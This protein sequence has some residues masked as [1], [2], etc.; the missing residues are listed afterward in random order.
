M[1]KIGTNIAYYFSYHFRQA[2]S[3]Y[4]SI[5]VC[6]LCGVVLG[7]VL[8]FTTTFG[9]FVLNDDNQLLF[10]FVSCDVS[11]AQFVVSKIGN[12]LIAFLILFVCSLSFYSS[13]ICF[14]FF[15]YQNLL[16]SSCCCEIAGAYGTLGF[17][18]VLFVLIPVNVIMFLV[19]AYFCCVCLERMLLAKKYK[20]SLKTSF[21][22]KRH[23]WREI[24][25][26]V[27][28]GVLAILLL[29]VVYSILL[30]NVSFVVF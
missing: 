24:V 10:D 16:L 5:F 27:S 30:R 22:Y 26:A 6:A 9:A 7:V 20:M 11:L 28:F 4:F 21:L 25:A 2:K 15:V 29:S 23:F 19:L 17:A 12:L 1:K 14:A 3:L 13:L 18:N 8:H